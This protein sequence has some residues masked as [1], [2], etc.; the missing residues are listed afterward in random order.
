MNTYRLPKVFYDDHI[1]RDLLGGNII[2][3]TRTHYFIELSP[4]A[5]LDIIEDAKLYID[6][7]P[8]LQREYFGLVSSA[9]ATIKALE[10]E[11]EK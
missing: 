11:I 7:A 8:D 2:K 1:N 3:E 4:E 6:L 5:H 10:K 9:R